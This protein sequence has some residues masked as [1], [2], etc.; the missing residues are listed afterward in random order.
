MRTD[1]R[2][3][4]RIKIELF[5]FKFFLQRDMASSSDSGATPLFV[6]DRNPNESIKDC[7][8]EAQVIQEQS[9][10]G[11]IAITS[12]GRTSKARRKSNK[13]K[14]KPTPS[15]PKTPDDDDVDEIDWR[16]YVDNSGEYKG[17]QPYTTLFANLDL[18]EEDEQD[19]TGK[20]DDKDN[21]DEDFD[22]EAEEEAIDFE[23]S[24]SDAARVINEAEM[25]GYNLDEAAEDSASDSEVGSIRNPHVLFQYV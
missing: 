11:F 10:D 19:E 18:S 4:K 23:V 14:N 16:D 2:R 13:G 25:M 7:V 8:D 6:I 20:E 17:W 24:V 21:D 1:G 22:E 3:C 5:L 9:D 12:S 15:K